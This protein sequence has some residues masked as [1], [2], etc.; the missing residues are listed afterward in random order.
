MNVKPLYKVVVLIVVVGP[1]LATV[2]AISLLWQRAVHLEDVALLLVT[3]ALTG[4]GFSMHMLAGCS[5]ILILI[6]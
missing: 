5:K 4:M 3:Y 1:L 2:F 6:I